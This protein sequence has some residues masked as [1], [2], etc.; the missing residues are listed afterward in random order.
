MASDEKADAY[1]AMPMATSIIVWMDELRRRKT[2]APRT[3]IKYLASTAGALAS[4]PLYRA[5]ACS[6]MLSQWPEWRQALLGAAK[7]AQ[8]ALPRAPQSATRAEVNQAIRAEVKLHVRTAMM[9]AWVVAGRTGDVSRLQK[10]HVIIHQG[11]TGPTI[12]VTWLETK[13]STRTGPR[14]VTAAVP[15]EWISTL[16]R[17]LEQRN[18]WLF[19]K[20]RTILNTEIRV[21]LRRIN[22]RLECRSL[23]RGALETMARAGTPSAVILEF[24]GHTTEKM[25]RTYLGWGRHLSGVTAATTAASGALLPPTA[26]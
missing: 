11:P 12:S 17:Y 3:L 5:G 13:T 26:G 16:Q 21:A 15:Q 22:P 23:R 4:L 9:I 6:I 2:W 18:R 19:A 1:L 25:L 20:D 14:S 24:S 8:R 7:L 10:E